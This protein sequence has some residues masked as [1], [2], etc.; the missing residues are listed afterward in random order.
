MRI[1]VIVL[2]S[3]GVASKL[4]RGPF[5]K[6]TSSCNRGDWHVEKGGIQKRRQ[7]TA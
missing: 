7:R 3:G 5:G 1:S 6:R 4:K 2:S